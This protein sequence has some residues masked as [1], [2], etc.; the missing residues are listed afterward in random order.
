MDKFSKITFGTWGLSE[1][2]NYSKKYCSHLCNMAYTKGI[3]SFDTAPVY[4]NGKAEETLSTLS[5]DCFI[6]TKIPSKDRS[7]KVEE[8]YETSWVEKCINK[9]RKRLSKDAL[10]L[11]Q[12]HN[13]D[14][15]WQN[16]DELIYLMNDLKQK[17]IVKN[18]GISLPVENVNI[19]NKIFNEPLVEYFQ[20]HYNLLQQQNKDLIKHLKEK[21]KN[22]FLRSVLLHGFLLESVNPPFE[23]K[24][25]DNERELIKKRTR[26]FKDV[27][28]EDRFNYCLEDAFSTGASSIILGITKKNQLEGIEKYL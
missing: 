22:V 18:W 16:Y 7:K 20:V 19:D 17:G 13:W 25:S 6:A 11:V 26:L 8:A 4:G 27:Q 3:I 21:G 24:Y 1:W 15:Q 9:S 12:I 10:D 28:K 5:N 14:Y 2:N 23:K